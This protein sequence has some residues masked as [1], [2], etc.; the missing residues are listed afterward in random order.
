MKERA[1]RWAAP[2]LSFLLPG[3]VMLAVSAALG[4]A[5][6]GDNTILI[7]DMSTQYVEF[8]CALKNGDLFFS[9]SKALGTAYVGV[10]SYYVSS[11]LSL[12]TL[13]VPNEQ[14]PVGLLFL[15]VLLSFRREIGKEG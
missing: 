6:W 2:A 13:L 1:E 3:L 4:M 15:A 11:P 7:S 14:M 5:P 12:L 10:F 8:F 9:W